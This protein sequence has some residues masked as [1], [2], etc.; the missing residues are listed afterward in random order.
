MLPS[1]YVSPD[2]AVSIDLVLP[3]SEGCKV[4]PPEILSKAV[5]VEKRDPI[6]VDVAN[7]PK[8]RKVASAKTCHMKA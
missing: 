4:A 2:V 5:L 7:K 1:G 3:L 6:V 8:F